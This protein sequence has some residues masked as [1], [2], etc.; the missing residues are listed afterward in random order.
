MPSVRVER[1][2][3][4]TLGLGILGFDHL[5]LVY[6]TG[7][8][9]SGPED[10]WFVIEGL[11][12]ASPFGLRLG[13]EG[14]YGATTLA[15]AN[16][17]V[18]GEALKAKIGTADARGS[19]EIATGP[20]A[21]QLWA[22]FVAHASDI[23][24]Q[25][26]PYIAYALPTSPLP[27]LNSSSL[28]SSLLHH[29]GLD[30]ARV[31]PYGLRFSPGTETLLGT[32]GDDV[33]SP[34][35]RFTAVMAGDGADRLTGSFE[36]SRIDKLYGGKGNDHFQWSKGLNIIHGGQP[37]LAYGDDGRDTVDYAGV[38]QVTIRAGS[39]PHPHLSPDFIATFDGGEDRLFSIEEIVWDGAGDR[40][41]LGEGAG[42]VDTP[43]TLTPGGEHN[44]TRGD[45][46]DLSHSQHGLLIDSGQDAAGAAC[47]AAQVSIMAT[48][49]Y[50]VMG[51]EWTIGSPWDDQ[52]S[53]G[54]ATRGIE[55]GAG[56]DLIDASEGRLERLSGPRG[57]DMEVSGGA[58]RD[59]IVS[60]PGRVAARGGRGADVFV[61]GPKTEELIIED[62]E[63]HDRLSIRGSAAARF[64]TDG[65]T[66]NDL[67]I[68]V[69]REG[70]VVGDADAPDA[71]IRVL[72]FRE[73]DLGL[74]FD[75]RDKP[76]FLVDGSAAF[77]DA[78]SEAA[79]LPW[80]WDEVPDRVGLRLDSAVAT[81][82]FRAHAMALVYDDDPQY[83]D[84]F[85]ADD[86]DSCP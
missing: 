42:L 2:P 55:G 72:G 83:C 10:A 70:G 62:A 15:E 24:A 9:V 31:T 71:L 36:P 69:S 54:A 59:M 41:L 43:I 34:V 11:R 40:V 58:G 1:L 80:W 57:F 66:P 19:R 17:G 64:E 65:R 7:Q 53:A 27:T 47:V 4:Q 49:A 37:A 16:G 12:E 46:M 35:E 23:A 25:S 61:L 33:L 8:D 56:D 32:S 30:I 79:G 38:G 13:V 48:C 44:G 18:T 21:P 76:L 68:R 28:V 51:A 26:F 3:I 45:V 63:P 67:L 84:G 50:R 75:A 78:Q 60:G 77:D 29:A 85:T 5:Q 82:D 86:P 22:T 14:L 6:V 74:S 81:S 52:I 20:E 73:G 39:A